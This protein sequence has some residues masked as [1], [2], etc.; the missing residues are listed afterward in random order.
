MHAV[1]GGC[2]L[3][4]DRTPL[5][6]TCL[7]IQ[8]AFSSIYGPVCR[9]VG[10]ADSQVKLRGFRLE[11]GEVEAVLAAV[12]S[13]QDAVAVLQVGCC[14]LCLLLTHRFVKCSATNLGQ[15]PSSNALCWPL[16]CRMP[17]RRPPCWL[18]MSPRRQLTRLRC[19]RRRTPSCRPTW[20]PLP[21]SGW[22]SYRT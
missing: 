7:P 2:Q 14:S 11:L 6:C 12:D 8:H 15:K 16:V 18:H 17:T 5:A 3:P 4:G 20:Y 19:W 10:R 1:E 9:Y 13:V 21:S 22:P